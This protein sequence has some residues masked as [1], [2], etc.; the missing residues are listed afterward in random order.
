MQVRGK[1]SLVLS[2]FAQQCVNSNWRA[3]SKKENVGKH[4]FVLQH[5]GLR[6][7]V[8]AVAV[9]SYRKKSNNNM[10]MVSFLKCQLR[11]YVY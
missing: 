3:E 5:R 1:L 7:I 9:V 2:G 8:V 4:K 11:Q 6:E 10:V